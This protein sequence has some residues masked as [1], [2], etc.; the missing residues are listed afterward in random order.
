MN[1]LVWGMPVDV[2]G[3]RVGF[4][5]SGACSFLMLHSSKLTRLPVKNNRSY[6]PMS[7]H[8]THSGLTAKPSDFS[9]GFVTK[10]L[11]EFSQVVDNQ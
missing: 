1:L 9:L 5:D 2:I 8:M 10:H 7:R 3:D 6:F 4:S 11:F